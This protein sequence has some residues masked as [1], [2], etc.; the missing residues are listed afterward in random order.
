MSMR[1]YG[2][3]GPFKHS[4]VMAAVLF[5]AC[6]VYLPG[7]DGPFEGQPGAGLVEGTPNEQKTTAAIASSSGSTMARTETDRLVE[8]VN[9]NSIGKHSGKRGLQDW[10]AR[11]S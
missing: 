4:S 10:A 3:R 5:A 1:F 9:K 6:G 2:F 8:T 11:C 7:C